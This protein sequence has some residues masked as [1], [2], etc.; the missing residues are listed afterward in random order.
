MGIGDAT[1]PAFEK[2]L[3]DILEDMEISGEALSRD[4]T[5]EIFMS[6]EECV[7]RKLPKVGMSRWFGFVDTSAHFQKIWSR[8]CSVNPCP[9]AVH[10]V[11]LR[12]QVGVYYITRVLILGFVF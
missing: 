3:P 1:D 2:H 6:L 8:R 12:Q 11:C 10:Y 9:S 7:S 4:M 5:A